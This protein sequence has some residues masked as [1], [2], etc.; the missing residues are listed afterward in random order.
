M[1]FFPT[2]NADVAEFLSMRAKSALHISGNEHEHANAETLSVARM[3]SVSLYEPE[4]MI[5]SVQSGILL[6]ELDAVLREKKQWLPMLQPNETH[7]RTLGGAVATDMYHPRSRAS[8]MLRT[9]ILGGTFASTDGVVF[10]SG[11]RVVKS[12][13]GYDIHRAFCGSQGLFG[14]ILEIT[15]KVQPLPEKFYRFLAPLQI[16]EKI[17]SMHPTCLEELD[18]KLLVEL[19]GFDEDIR[20]DM[21]LLSKLNLIELDSDAWSECVKKVIRAKNN[22][23]KLS[24]DVEE[25]LASVRRTFDPE[26]VLV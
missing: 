11:S 24:P 17:L 6:E 1:P 15:F 14:V 8:G 7:S 9:A 10:K 5:I 18:G 12:V 21:K 16:R 3:N 22:L 4:E 26:G 19:A 23:S 25:L 20:E 2:S 13:A